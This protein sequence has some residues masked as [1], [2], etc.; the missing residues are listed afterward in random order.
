M[1]LGKRTF[2]QLGGFD[3]ALPVYYNDTDLCNRARQAGLRIV[4]CPK[5]QL[6]H[7]GGTSRA[8][9]EGPGPGRLLYR[10]RHGQ[11][12][13]PYAS[14]N[15]L[16]GPHWVEIRPRRASRRGRKRLR[17]AAFTH[18]LNRTGAPLIQYN[19]LRRLHADG[20]I[21]L[22]G[23]LSPEEGSL[24]QGYEQSG[25]FVEVS[26][27][28][29]RVSI[30]ADVVYANTL[31][32]Q[33]AIL[34]SGRP[35]VWHVHESVPGDNGRLARAFEATYGV[36]FSTEATRDVYAPMGVRHSHIVENGLDPDWFRP[37]AKKAAR[38]RL[39]LS[40]RDLVV[41]SVGTFE[42]RKRH[43]DVVHACLELP[44][45]LF[46][47][48]RW[49]HAGEQ[50]RTD[51]AKWLKWLLD[52]LH[53]DFAG[54]FRRFGVLEDTND[55]FAAADVMVMSSDNESQPMV[56]IEAM[57]H[58]TPIITTPVYGYRSMVVP[59]ANALVYQAGDVTGLLRCLTRVLDDPALRASMSDASLRCAASWP[60]FASQ[61]ERTL[62][63]L[64]EAY[65]AG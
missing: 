20:A 6:I 5:A 17:V 65:L 13:E 56:L 29:Y 58:G 9:D 22:T 10:E 36:I 52:D 30:G 60:T 38:A 48:L 37:T 15:M 4:Y 21:I 34:E 16:I 12:A 43:E 1:L 44:E 26:G 14:P 41:A 46:G 23:V 39:G 62:G 27:D 50:D 40:E 7:P 42:T 2:D 53:P 3:E 31:A 35:V 28:P 25:A 45:S 64:W 61:C 55:L 63:L 47:R 24:R 18:M 57:A 59:G 51:H 19:V 33:D 11:E 32:M 49:I 8:G 54:R